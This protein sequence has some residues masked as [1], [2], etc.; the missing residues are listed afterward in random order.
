[1]RQS[2]KDPN[3]WSTVPHGG[4]VVLSADDLVPLPPPDPP[5]LRGAQSVVFS[6]D[7]AGF[8]PLPKTEITATLTGDIT[9]TFTAVPTATE[10]RIYT[11]SQLFRMAQARRRER[12]LRK[13]F[14]RRKKQAR[15]RTGRR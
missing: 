3:V 2:E 4:S 1:M 8:Y 7:E 12:Q 9:I 10:Y 6:I 11:G 14:N 5:K 13:A 15:A